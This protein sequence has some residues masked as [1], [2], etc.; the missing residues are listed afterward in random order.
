MDGDETCFLITLFVKDHEFLLK[1]ALKALEEQL[2][3]DMHEYPLEP[4]NKAI[5]HGLL[6]DHLQDIGTIVKVEEIFDI[7][8]DIVQ[9]LHRGDASVGLPG[10]GSRKSSDVKS[11]TQGRRHLESINTRSKI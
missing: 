11:I 2:S 5:L 7:Y 6:P 4:C 9:P 3:D 8:T 1:V 10:T